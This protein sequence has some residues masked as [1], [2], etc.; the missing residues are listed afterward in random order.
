MMAPTRT[1]HD[2]W[3]DQQQIE[4]IKTDATTSAGATWDLID[5]TETYALMDEQEAIRGM[6]LLTL[7]ALESQWDDDDSDDA[8]V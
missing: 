2:Y 6:R 4:E 8:T 7:R 3:R 5:V 1:L